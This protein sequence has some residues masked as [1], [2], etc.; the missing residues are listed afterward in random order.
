MACM[1]TSATPPGQRPKRVA[2]AEHTASELALL[3]Y[4]IPNERIMKECNVSADSASRWRNGT[5]IPYPKHVQPIAT[6][7]GVPHEEISAVIFRDRQARDAR[8]TA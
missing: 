1:T 3:L 5:A 6:M 4:A 8:R 2:R 7:L